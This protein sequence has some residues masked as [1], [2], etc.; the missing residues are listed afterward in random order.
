MALFDQP[1]TDVLS[2]RAQSTQYR[3]EYPRGDL[4]GL[5]N[6]SEVLIGIGPGWGF[7]STG[8]RLLY[9]G[10]CL[11]PESATF[12]V[13]GTPNKIDDGLFLEARL[14]RIT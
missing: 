1:D 10:A 11:S 3:I 4:P 8:S 6:N 14:Q 2:G 12:K 5:T 9:S 13:L 7:D